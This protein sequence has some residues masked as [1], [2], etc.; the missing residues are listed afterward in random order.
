MKYLWLQ[1]YHK[2]ES[3]TKLLKNHNLIINQL[4]IC[5]K[6]IKVMVNTVDSSKSYPRCGGAILRP[7]KLYQLWLKLSLYLKVLVPAA[8][9]LSKNDRSTPPSS[10]QSWVEWLDFYQWLRLY[11]ICPR[12]QHS[13]IPLE[14][15]YIL[16]LHIFFQ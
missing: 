13:H 3:Y 6:K 8:L 12:C 5:Y 1:F 4:I 7:F 10:C 16:P 2:S 11:I 14:L 15:N 9:L